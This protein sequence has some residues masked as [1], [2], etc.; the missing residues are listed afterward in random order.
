M[1]RYWAARRANTV[2]LPQCSCP[3]PND[4]T[5]AETEPGSANVD[6][7]ADAGAPSVGWDYQVWQGDPGDESLTGSGQF[8]PEASEE[9]L[10]DL[11]GPSVY[12]RLR[13]QCGGG[14]ASAYVQSNSIVLSLVLLLVALSCVS[15]SGPS[16]AR[17]RVSWQQG[18]A[19]TLDF[20][21][22]QGPVTNSMPVPK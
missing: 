19:F 6:W 7:G 11:T 10:S 9:G 20:G 15:C 8:P 18:P 22:V 5:L 14:C 1:G 21:L 3:G 4:V 17:L 12:V 13:G 16:S 2:A